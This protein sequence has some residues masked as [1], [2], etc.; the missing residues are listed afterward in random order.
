MDGTSRAAIFHNAHRQRLRPGRS[1]A[2][3]GLFQVHSLRTVPEC[4]PHLPRAGPGNGF[5]A[6]AHLPDDPGGEG[7]AADGRQFCPAHRPLPGLPRLRDG[8]PLGRRIRKAGGS[9]AR[10]NRE[11]ITSAHSCRRLLRQL[12]FHDLLP[13]R[14][15][16][17]R[18]RK[19]L[20]ILPGLG[21]GEGDSQLAG[22][23]AFSGPAGKSGA[24][25]AANGETIFHRASGHSRSARRAAQISRG[26]LCRM[27]RQSFFCAARMTQRCACW[28]AMAAKW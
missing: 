11:A 13:S 16:I 12:F 1:A 21:T 8:L 7:P 23:E 10:T 19:A 14:C 20:A 4:L 3:G 18:W 22:A 26:F 5:A 24:T 28:R 6:R 15:S 9:G 17:W 25:V 2:L 27:H